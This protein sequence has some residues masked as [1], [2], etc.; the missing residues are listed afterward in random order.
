M[1]SG[2]LLLLKTTNGVSGKP[3]CSSF[4]LANTQRSIHD[5]RSFASFYCYLHA[6]V[7]LP[8][9]LAHLLDILAICL[10]TTKKCALPVPRS[11][12]LAC[13]L[14][15]LFHWLCTF[16]RRMLW[17]YHD[18]KFYRRH[19]CFYCRTLEHGFWVFLCNHNNYGLVGTNKVRSS[20]EI[21]PKSKSRHMHSKLNMRKNWNFFSSEDSMN[22]ANNCTWITVISSNLLR[23]MY[24][25][26]AMKFACGS[27]S[28][29][30]QVNKIILYLI[31][32]Y[33]LCNIYVA[34]CLVKWSNM[35]ITNAQLKSKPLFV[36]SAVF[37]CS[38]LI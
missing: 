24:K 28:S 17:I 38:L 13:V 7:L 2:H 33:S 8:M 32:T 22:Y 20:R 1:V 15:L 14:L 37:A 25:S 21:Q 4:V 19:L 36:M 6:R 10:P 30:A 26:N 23:R 3:V 18:A 11:F 27:A 12:S 16:S 34:L 9:V 31:K 29:R 35:C 5:K